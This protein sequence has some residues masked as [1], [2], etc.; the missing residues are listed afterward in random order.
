MTSLSAKSSNFSHLSAHD[1]QLVRLGLLAERYFAEDPN[2]CLLKLRQLT[3]LLAQLIASQIGLFVSPEE[4]QVDLLRRLQG[5]GIVPREVGTL[6]AEVRKAGNAANHRLDGDHRTALTCMRLT[7]QL[8]LWFHRTFKDAAYKSGPF[9]PPSAPG[10]ENAELQAELAQLRVELDQ[11][12]AAHN[13]ATQQLDATRTQAQQTEEE[14]TF[15]ENMAAEA[16]AAK[17][18]LA[19]RL[20]T[21]QVEAEA[22]PGPVIAEFVTAANTAAS[23]I[24]INEADTRKLIDS[25]LA[26]AGWIVDSATLTY[27]KGTRPQ[28]NKN[29][30]IAEWPTET[31]PADYVLFVG[32]T[33]VA[34][35]EAKRKN[36]DVSGA[37]QQAKRYSR[38]FRASE[39]TV[40]P[41]INWGEEG[42]YRVPFAFSSNGRP[43][44]RQLAT[45]SGVWFCDLRRPENLSHALDG[46]YTPEGLTA[47]IKRDEVKAHEQLDNAPFN[48]GFNLRYY[49]QDAIRASEQAI[50]AGQREMLLAMATGTGKTKTC[51]ALIYRLLK[52]QRFNRILFLVD[53]S[54]LGEQAANAFKDTRMENLQTFADIFGIKE[55]EEQTPDTDTSVHIATVQGMVQRVLFASDETNPP[56]VDQYDCI[57]VDECHRGYLLDRELSD[58]ELTFR[59]YDDYISKYSRVLDYFDAVKIGLT[60][61]PALHTSKIFGPP[62]YTYSYRE[63]VIDGFLVDYEPPIQ[64]TTE[65][66]ANGIQWKVGENVKVYDTKRDQIE[67]YK[68]PDEIKLDVEV[69]N[70]KVITENFNRVVC[71]YLA[72]ELDPSSNRKTLIFCATDAHADLVVDLLKQAF[73]TKYGSVEDDAVI[74]ITGAADKP[75]QLIRRYKNEKHPNVAVTVDLLTTGIDVPEICNLVFL[76][77]VNSRILFDQMLGR[78]TRLCEE[79]E[80]DAFRVFDAVQIFEALQHMTAMQPVV[81]DPKISFTQLASE[82]ASVTDDEARALVRDQFLAKLQRKKRHL[83]EKG[84]RDFETRA[85]M[86]PDA[87]IQKL[88]AM[89][90]VD[91]AAWFTQNPDL[92]EILDRKGDG[93]REPIFISEHP[94]QLKT[95]ERGYGQ[96]KKPE[97]YLNEFTAFIKSHSNTIPALM[98]VLTRPRELTRKQLRELVVELDKAGFTETGLSTAWRE[99]TNQDIAARIV[100][101]IRQAAIGDALVPYSERVD[102]ALQKLLASRAWTTPQ[103]DWLKKIAA[104]TKANTLVDREALDDV[105]LLF[106]TQGGGFNRLDK[107]FD[108]QLL[109]TLEA[110]NDAIWPQPSRPA[111]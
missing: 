18:E 73:V 105:D 7:W 90:L 13:E 96:A 51:I 84:G 29:L 35:V 40:L 38:T 49:Q 104:Q 25:Q 82:L 107:V 78:A 27:A 67:L 61:T 86:T 60:A 6:F 69:F 81:A 20:E 87:F 9:V 32:F 45:K 22:Q 54:A 48:Y 56:A 95:V 14:R 101:Y 85:G 30:A 63:A 16:E 57:V 93:P 37:L 74:K 59:G 24:Q 10:D 47:L 91:V 34:V 43:Y 23:A 58:T 108:G 55:L 12:R 70:R 98:T 94:D 102:H 39:E 4:K 65:L 15:W 64:I 99:M 19:K 79:I 110:F 109:Q 76:R 103:R 44:L 71:E 5:H 62:I 68:A 28:K 80:K 106:K 97:D 26:A 17:H 11:Y 21:M 42:A 3:E 53:R 52:A 75:L 46:W 50:E 72:Q 100:G 111:A 89:P 31:G 8:S 92:G 77:R 88:R 33:P 66:S 2:T 36:I 83:G 41:E 1:E